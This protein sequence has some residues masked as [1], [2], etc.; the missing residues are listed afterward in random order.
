MK[1]NEPTNKEIEATKE[2]VK[3]LWKMLPKD[4]QEW[5]RKIS[6]PRENSSE[7]GEPKTDESY[8]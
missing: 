6:T 3:N 5:F 4:T 7:K 8:S 2:E 1:Q